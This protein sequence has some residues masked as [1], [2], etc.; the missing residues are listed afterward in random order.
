[1]EV[2]AGLKFLTPE[3]LLKLPKLTAFP[4]DK[5]S[6]YSMVVMLLLPGASTPPKNTPRV[7]ED[8]PP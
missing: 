6:M 7:G 3:W 1:M 2:P 4:V 5:I 8:V